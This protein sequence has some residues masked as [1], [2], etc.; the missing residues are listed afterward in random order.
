MVKCRTLSFV[1]TILVMSVLVLAPLQADEGPT[2]STT[3]R[4]AVIEN[5]GV[6]YGVTFGNI[7]YPGFKAA[8]MILAAPQ[9]GLAWLLTL[10]DNQQARTVWESHMEEP[11]FISAE[12]ARKAMGVDE[13]SKPY[14]RELT[15]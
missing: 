4:E 2:G 3:T 6:A 13:E 11:Y 15:E 10:G 12:Q 8:T 1:G 14:E 7:F 9:A 5:A